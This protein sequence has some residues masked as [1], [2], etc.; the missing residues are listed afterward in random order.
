MEFTNL[1]L[2]QMFNEASKVTI[3]KDTYSKLCEFEHLMNCYFRSHLLTDVE[4]YE[5]HHVLAVINKA[6][7]KLLENKLG[8]D[9]D[10]DGIIGTNN[11]IKK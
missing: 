4:R 8:V 9:L 10:N 2:K 3:T 11:V 7:L 6:Q 1:F 5:Y